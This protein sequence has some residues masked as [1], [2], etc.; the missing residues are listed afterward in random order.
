LLIV[1]SGK[2]L[3]TKLWRNL[4]PSLL[5]GFD[6]TGCIDDKIWPENKAFCRSIVV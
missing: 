2:P 3:V 5:G 6:W 1:T 4:P